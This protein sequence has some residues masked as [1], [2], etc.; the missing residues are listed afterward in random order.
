MYV[1]IPN[2]QALRVS[3]LN[4]ERQVDLGAGENG[5]STVGCEPDTTLAVVNK[6]VQ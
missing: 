6:P 5:Q 4:S 1:C 2:L 3:S